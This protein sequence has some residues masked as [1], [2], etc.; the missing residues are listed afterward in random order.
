MR[1]CA[2][3]FGSLL[4]LALCGCA[5]KP[6]AKPKGELC[7]INAQSEHP[8]K[9]CFN[10][11]T[12]FDDDLKLKPDAKGTRIPV[13]LADLHKWWATDSFTKEELES[14]AMKWK[15]RYIKLEKECR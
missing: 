5:N 10:L 1:L 12:D 9:L 14:Y 7:A 6:P 3:V 8:Y 2:A 13:E 4:A 11:E 15:A